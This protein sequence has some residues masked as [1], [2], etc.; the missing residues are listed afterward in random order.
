MR[1]LRDLMTVRLLNSYLRKTLSET[2]IFAANDRKSNN[3]C[4]FLYDKEL[5]V[6]VLLTS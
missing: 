2:M 6:S 1:C 4:S 5:F 3:V